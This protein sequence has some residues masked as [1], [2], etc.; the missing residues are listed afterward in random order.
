MIDEVLQHFSRLVHSYSYKES[1]KAFSP[2]RDSYR[3]RL[4]CISI[5]LLALSA[6]GIRV[7]TRQS[8]ICFPLFVLQVLTLKKQ[9]KSGYFHVFINLNITRQVSSMIHSA[10][11]QSGP[12][13]I[14]A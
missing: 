11:P 7:K 3:Q 1:N 6:K 14:I 4:A 5:I 10:S 9:S 13:V 2:K 8:K 12:A